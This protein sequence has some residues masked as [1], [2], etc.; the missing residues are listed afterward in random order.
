MSTRIRGKRTEAAANRPDTHEARRR[1]NAPKGC[2]RSAFR[3][4]RLST[5]SARIWYLTAVLTVAA[6]T[7]AMVSLRHRAGPVTRGY[8]DGRAN[9]TSSAQG[10]HVASFY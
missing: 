2:R 3:R 1:T 10:T 7:I 5:V 8:G 6:I 4:D 9:L